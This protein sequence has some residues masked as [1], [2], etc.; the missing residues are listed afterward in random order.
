M[1][2][3][4]EPGNKSTITAWREHKTVMWIWS[5]L[6]IDM[7]LGGVA[8]FDRLV[9]IEELTES[10]RVKSMWKVDHRSFLFWTRNTTAILLWYGLV[11]ISKTRYKNMMNFITKCRGNLWGSKIMHS[12]K[13][14]RCHKHRT[15]LYFTDFLA[16]KT[17]FHS[18]CQ[19]FMDFPKTLWTSAACISELRWARN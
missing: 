4:V 16:A 1:N 13:V 7:D 5:R 10:T 14:F 15:V 11:V 18:K 9:K 2:R 8:N 6:L 12:G 17:D 19:I 3:L